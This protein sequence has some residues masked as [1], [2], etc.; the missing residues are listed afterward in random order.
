MTCA[1]TC[2]YDYTMIILKRNKSLLV[3]ELARNLDSKFF[4]SLGEPVRQELLKYLLMNGRSDIGTIA[5]HL[6]QDRS[7]ISRHLQLM[8]KTGI[9]NCEKEGRF[10]YYSINGQDF[11]TKLESFVDQVRTCIPICCP[12]SCCKK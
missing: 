2:I 4:R 3:K 10:M 1:S 9:L 7:V 11:L 6:P 5:Q 12:P 8:Q